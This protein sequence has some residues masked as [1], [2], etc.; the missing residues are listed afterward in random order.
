MCIEPCRHISDIK[1]STGTPCVHNSLIYWANMEIRLNGI[2][3]LFNPVS[4][5]CVVD[6][7]NLSFP[8]LSEE[9]NKHPISIWFLYYITIGN[10]L[11]LLFEDIS[12]WMCVGILFCRV[13]NVSAVPESCWRMQARVS[14]SGMGLTWFPLWM[15]CWGLRCP[16][17][18]EVGVQANCCIATV[19]REC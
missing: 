14:F 17:Q 7:L 19:L 15:C 11:R 1:Y 4:G 16:W 3:V 6:Y 10:V 5:F 8:F 9:R 13:I 2:C 18:Q 12:V